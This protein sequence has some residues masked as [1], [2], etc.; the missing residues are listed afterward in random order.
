MTETGVDIERRD[1]FAH[2]AT[3]AE[4]MDFEGPWHV[5]LTVK[6]K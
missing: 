4:A 5:H 1:D 3:I 6:K 2:L